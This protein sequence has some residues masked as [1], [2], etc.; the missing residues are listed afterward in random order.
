MSKRAL[1]YARVSDRKQEDNYSLPDQTASIEELCRARGYQFL[2]V[3]Q[4]VH[5]GYE[6][7]ERPVLMQLRDRMRKKEFDVLIVWRLDRLSRDQNH[8]A[9]LMHQMEKYDVQIELANGDEITNDPMG[10][11]ILATR[12]LLAE[13][14]RA[15][16]RER[17][18]AGLRRRAL[19]GKMIPYTRPVYGYRWGDETKAF[20][21]IDE[22]TAVIVLRIYHDAAG[23]KRMRTIAR[24]L[25]VEGM[26]IP[27]DQWL[28]DNGKP[29]LH[30]GW[31]ISTVGKILSNPAY[32]GEYAAFAASWE[33]RREV[34]IVTGQ[35]KRVHT[36]KARGTD[37]PRRIPIEGVCPAIVTRV[38]ADAVRDR[39][40]QNREEASRNAR[41]P[42]GT[43]L[44]G[45]F[46][47]C[48]ECGTKIS[49]QHLYGKEDRQ[50]RYFQYLC[51]RWQ[52]TR[53]ACN[54]SIGSVG[55]DRYV[56]KLV[57][58]L[59]QDPDRLIQ[60]VE[61]RTAVEFAQE[62]REG[63]ESELE[64]IT[65]RRRKLVLRMEIEDDPRMLAE[66]K[67][68]S[69]QLAEEEDNALE[70]LRKLNELA[71]SM[72]KRR[73]MLED[74]ALWCEELRSMSKMDAELPY[75]LKRL[76][77]YRFRIRVTINSKDSEE[78]V[79]VFA[80]DEEISK[81]QGAVPAQIVSSGG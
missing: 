3:L 33:K 37:D 39:L 53:N 45:G 6:L 23:G 13:M 34:D 54:V 4:E 12:A 61:Q 70:K 64:D 15:G 21:V 55:V 63:L 38:L 20:W 60:K 51:P 40:A 81:L 1:G 43:L 18:Q 74:L 58:E 65:I 69:R 52:R 35:A 29:S 5:T 22:R 10:K 25:N 77:L 68:R 59:I 9:V 8:V 2:G 17:T 62:D 76:A 19:Q 27:S 32:L 41:Y 14:E 28:L 79:R 30:R 72:E 48:G 16:I 67:E 80:G 56:W 71:Q 26:P 42:E 47:R 50:G 36:I 57:R 73:A 49:Q 7:D 31:S 78:R 11:F 44:R 66:I 46:A 24:E 75:M